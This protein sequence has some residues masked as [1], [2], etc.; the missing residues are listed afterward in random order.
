[1][2][3]NIVKLT[4]F[5]SLFF[6][7]ILTVNK[8]ALAASTCTVNDQEVPCE[9]FIS[10]FSGL[11]GWGLGIFVLLFVLGIWATVFWIMMLV[12]VAKHNSEDK[13]MWVLLMVFTGIIGSLV[14]YFVVKRKFDK[15]STSFPSSPSNQPPTPPTMMAQ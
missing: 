1:M 9:E 12:H 10:D 8:I 5:S 15:Q 13:I 2:L 11:L 3:K 4:S 7:S 14:Y 6:G